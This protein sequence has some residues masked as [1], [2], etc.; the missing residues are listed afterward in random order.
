MM[1]RGRCILKP[2]LHDRQSLV[3]LIVSQADY[4]LG[5][6]MKKLNDGKQYR[7]VVELFDQQKGKNMVHSSSMIITQFLK[8][9]AHTGD[10]QRA[11]MIRASVDHRIAND[12][13]I[14]SSFIHLYSEFPSLSRIIGTT[15]PSSSVVQ[16]GDV[17]DVEFLFQRATKKT[18]SIYGAMMKAFA[19]FFAYRRVSMIDGSFARLFEEPQNSESH[20]CLP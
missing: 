17:T 7:Q 16:C 9:C 10:L 13:Y 19:Q 8:A 12:T 5:F 14:L 3:R 15:S 20:R 1:I 11:S 2:F 6:R 4:E 18:L